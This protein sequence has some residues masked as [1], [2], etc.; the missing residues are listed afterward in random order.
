MLVSQLLVFPNFCHRISCICSIISLFHW[1]WR[2]RNV[3][4]E[5][6]R[7]RDRVWNF[8]NPLWCGVF[9][10]NLINHHAFHSRLYL[11][12]LDLLF[13]PFMFLSKKVFT[14]GM[15]RILFWFKFHVRLEGKSLEDNF[16]GLGVCVVRFWCLLCIT[17]GIRGKSKMLRYGSDEMFR[18][19]L[20]CLYANHYFFSQLFD[21]IQYFTKCLGFWP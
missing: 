12:T 3:C 14:E 6:Q 9:S 8:H 4:V 7:W 20:M 13:I 16:V 15:F 21:F 1:F 5:K 17:K 18:K 2:V 19:S 10:V 11:T